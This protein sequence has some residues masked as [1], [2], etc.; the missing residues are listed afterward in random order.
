MTTTPGPPA[1]HELDQHH[2][3]I[4][5]AVRGW[6][7]NVYPL[8]ITEHPDRTRAWWHTAEEL[9]AFATRGTTDPAQAI[10]L[11]AGLAAETLLLHS[12]VIHGRNNNP[13]D[14]S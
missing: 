12:E 8:V 5:A 4:I 11:L 6:V 7:D 14:R 13:D 1:V 2:A 9:A 3:A 10:A